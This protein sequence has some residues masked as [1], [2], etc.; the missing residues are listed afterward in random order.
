MIE[1]LF[2]RI[3]P[4]YHTLTDREKRSIRRRPLTFC[5]VA[6]AL[7]LYFCFSLLNNTQKDNRKWNETFVIPTKILADMSYV[8]KDA[9][10]V[11]C[12]TYVDNIYDIDM[13]NG[14]F[15]VSF[16]TWFRWDGD[17]ITDMADH[18]RIYQGSIL[19]KS[20]VK[21]YK[22]GNMHYQLLRAKVRVTHNFWTKSFPLDKHQLS[23][24]IEPY[25][26]AM[27]VV[28]VP[29][30][31]NSNVNLNLH[32][33][34]YGVTKAGMGAQ[35][36]EY[37]NTRGDVEIE[38]L[39]NISSE[40]VTSLQIKRDGLGLYVKCF[41]GLFGCLI[42][43]LMVLYINIYHRVDPLSMLPGALFGCVANIM[44]GASLLPD[45]LELGLLEYVNIW[46]I[47]IIL[48]VALVVMKINDMRRV[49]KEN[50]VVSYYTAV[51]G[52]LMFYSVTFLAVLGNVLMPAIVY[53]S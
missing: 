12:G 36:Y 26:T 50:K 8:S 17:D 45:A 48:S 25:Y 11:T 9:T 47:F 15:C 44:V 49:Y 6:G 41:I 34:G 27:R 31:E 20:I 28:L 16:L 2:L 21:N 5:L 4:H 33:S 19:N 18:F 35:A 23:F 39:K 42:W 30:K 32:I 51:Y 13:A 37:R 1:K 14:T 43:A 3:F 29:D 22:K 46:G 38:G 24:Y 10:K 40:I 53:F 7:L 52:R